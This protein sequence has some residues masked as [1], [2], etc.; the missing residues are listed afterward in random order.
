M[1]RQRWKLPSIVLRE[2]RCTGTRDRTPEPMVMNAAERERS[3][4]GRDPRLRPPALATYLPGHG[5]A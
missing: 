3:G 4:A 2:G 1:P 5:W